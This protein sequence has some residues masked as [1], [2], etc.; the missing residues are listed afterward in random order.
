MRTDTLIALVF[1]ALCYAFG[2]RWADK[3]SVPAPP[4]QPSI[5]RTT[6]CLSIS[7]I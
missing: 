1:V 6:P 5:E 2:V 4:K 7:K 3:P